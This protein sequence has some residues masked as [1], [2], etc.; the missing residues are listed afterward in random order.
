MAIKNVYEI[1][2]F[3]RRLFA[4]LQYQARQWGGGRGCGGKTARSESGLCQYEYVLGNLGFIF[5]FYNFYLKH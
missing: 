3:G 5:I 2:I 4:S 1:L